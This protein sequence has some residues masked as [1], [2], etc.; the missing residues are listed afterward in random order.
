MI[1]KEKDQRKSNLPPEMPLESFAF[2]VCSLGNE[3]SERV[4]LRLF[5]GLGVQ[6]FLPHYI[7]KAVV[8][9]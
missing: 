6:K 9:K 5:Q 7:H 4:D 3:N 1:D 2:C 8:I